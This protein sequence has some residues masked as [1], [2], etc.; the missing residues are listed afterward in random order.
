M[1][2]PLLA[3]L[4]LLPGLVVAQTSQQLTLVGVADPRPQDYADVWG[5]VAPDG[6]EYALVNARA[7]G[8]L[9]VM[10]LTD[11]DPVEVAFIPGPVAGG[12]G[13]DVEGYGHYVYVSDDRADVMVVSL[14][15]PEHPALVRTFD[16]NTNTPTDGTHTLT[17]SGDY[18]FTQGGPAPNGVRIWSLIPDPTR[19]ILVGEYH[20]YYVHDIMVRNDTLWTAGIYGDGVD[21]VDISDPFNPAL[22]NRFNYTGSGAHNICSTESGSYIYV[23]DEI[24]AGRWTRIFD[25]RDPQNVEL[26]GE[27]VVDAAAVVHNCYVVGD[28]LYIGHYTERA[29][30]FDISDPVHP[31]EIAYYDTW[32]GAPGTTDG[33]WSLY[34]PLPS[35][36][37]MATDRQLGL[38]VFR[39]PEGTATEPG[40]APGTLALQAAP[41]PVVGTGRVTFTLPEAGTVRLAVYD[42]LGRTVAVLADGTLPAGPQSVAFDASALPPGPY[43]ARLTA[44]AQSEVVRVTVSR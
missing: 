29:R 18:L 4:L 3:A 10:R 15:D 28:R 36:R 35:G 22:I 2:R 7:G 41:N 9:S 26:V 31:V 42:V 14:E 17:V 30:V 23:G 40:T 20:P 13:S 37:L 38:Y 19:P 1:L 21:I 24:G 6:T 43:L 16:P 11:G 25:V 12:F 27:I 34:K 44:G 39:M 8:G 33:V 32:P 5:Y